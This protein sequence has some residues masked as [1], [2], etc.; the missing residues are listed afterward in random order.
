M[1]LCWGFHGRTGMRMTRAVYVD[2]SEE[3]V[4]VNLPYDADQLAHGKPQTITMK[5]DAI[6]DPEVDRTAQFVV[7]SV[8]FGETA[9]S[10]NGFTLRFNNGDPLRFARQRADAS[11]SAGQEAV[12]TVDSGRS[13][14]P[15]N[16]GK[17][18]T[19]RHGRPAVPM[20]CDRCRRQ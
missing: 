5:L 11:V 16:D 17:E 3:P 4:Y 9:Y 1:Q 2:G 12:F 20:R 8:G 7:R 15:R 18:G 6:V 13:G 14:R 10:S 19:L